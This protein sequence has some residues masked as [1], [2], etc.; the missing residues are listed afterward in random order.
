MVVTVSSHSLC[1]ESLTFVKYFSGAPLICLAGI[2]SIVAR[3]DRH[4]AEALE[5]FGC[6]S[7]KFGRF[8]FSRIVL[9]SANVYR[10]SCLYVQIIGIAVVS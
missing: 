6:R 7:R 4:C 9:Y 5:R 2:K 3:G 10:A 1:V 8:R